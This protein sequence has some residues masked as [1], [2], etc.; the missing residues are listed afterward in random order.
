MNFHNIVLAIHNIVRWLVV[1][2]ALFALAR[3]YY[4]WLGRKGWTGQD[5]M[6][7]MI[8]TSLLDLQFLLG[9][10]LVLMAGIGNLG[11]FLY[12]HVI[13]MLLAVVL[14]HIGSTRARSVDG[15]LNRHR[16]AAIWYTLSVLVVLIAIPWL[17]PLFPRL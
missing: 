15:D 5:R 10:I 14:A 6:A 16:Q 4:G 11:S 7:G 1:L 3:A 17:R 13:P 12:E 9:I 8:F 2:A